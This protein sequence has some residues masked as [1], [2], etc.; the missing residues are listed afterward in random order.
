LIAE[1]LLIAGLA[2]LPW[3]SI[4]IDPLAKAAQLITASVALY[5]GWRASS[6]EDARLQLIS[7]ELLFRDQAKGDV[8]ALKLFV[9]NPS[10]RGNV[11][12]NVQVWRVELE[13][14]NKPDSANVI[15][16][17]LPI[18]QQPHS[19]GGAFGIYPA[20]QLG[21]A[22]VFLPSPVEPTRLPVGLQ[23]YE[24]KEI[25]VFRAAIETSKSGASS[26]HP[27][28]YDARNRAS[29]LARGIYRGRLPWWGPLVPESWLVWWLF[30]RGT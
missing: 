24:T 29:R 5:L 18:E 6:G 30:R 4:N 7:S 12:F 27:I 11:L 8:A 26:L 28:I 9:F 23:P 10:S 2:V 25:V 17:P 15:M 20:V 22:T 3:A 13:N 1:L 21:G 19:E 14:I 16:N